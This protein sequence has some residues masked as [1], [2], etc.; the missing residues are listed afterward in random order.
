MDKIFMNICDAILFVNDIMPMILN[1][2][3]TAIK[4][5]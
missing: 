1:L 3:Q 4:F 5:L 2:L